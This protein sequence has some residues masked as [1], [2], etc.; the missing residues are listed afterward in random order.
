MTAGAKGV[1]AENSKL[2][3]TIAH[4]EE[5]VKVLNREKEEGPGGSRAKELE[6]RV[7]EL[8]GLL[9]CERQARAE[10]EEEVRGSN[11]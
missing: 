11:M 6:G 3:S 2:R 5:E 1:Q 8:E 7:E 4:L 10:A 9:E